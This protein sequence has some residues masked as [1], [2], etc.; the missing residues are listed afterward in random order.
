MAIFQV[1]ITKLTIMCVRRNGA[2]RHYASVMRTHLG[3]MDE[4][5]KSGIRFR[6][7]IRNLKN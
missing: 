7:V 3:L 4:F 6:D 5:H 1:K 2:T